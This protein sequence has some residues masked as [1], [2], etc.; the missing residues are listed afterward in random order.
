[1]LRPSIP[2]NPAI[3][4][5][6]PFDSLF[7]YTDSKP[8]LKN[9]K[10]SSDFGRCMRLMKRAKRTTRIFAI[11]TLVA[12]L[13]MMLPVAVMAKGNDKPAKPAQATEKANRD[14]KPDKPVKPD[15][16]E[17]VK[18]NPQA[19]FIVLRNQWARDHHM[20]P[21]YVNIMYKYLVMTKAAPAVT[22]EAGSAELAFAGFTGYF[23]DAE[24]KITYSTW[25]NTDGT[26]NLETMMKDIKQFKLV[27][28]QSGIEIPKVEVPEVEEEE[29]DDDDEPKEV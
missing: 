10:P 18:S 8:R 14:E 13:V 24:L 12:L 19:A 29:L 21:G 3:P 16:T 17:K 22:K 23:T 20:P 26:F 5:K 7:S 27:A 4:E 11:L 9:Q 2:I 28:D 1:M 6:T 15:Q 25:F